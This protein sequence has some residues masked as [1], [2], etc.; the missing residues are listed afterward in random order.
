MNGNKNRTDSARNAEA[1]RV[2][3]NEGGALARDF[4]DHQYGRRV[5]ADRSWTVYHV[6]TGIPAHVDGA[7]MIGLNR[8]DAT[9]GMLSLN[10]RN[11][12]RRRERAAAR[13]LAPGASQTQAGQS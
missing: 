7:F 11:S 9:H 13:S 12:E 2:W 8:S 3:E 4:R 1:L 6:F 5:E 10:R